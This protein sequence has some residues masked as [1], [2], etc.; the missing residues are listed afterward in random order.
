MTK[1][2]AR[3]SA[4]SPSEYPEEYIALI[5][6]P[7]SPAEPHLAEETPD[8]NGQWWDRAERVFVDINE[9]GQ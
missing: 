8:N 3:R 5:V 7:G 4:F 1:P 6:Q 2:I 9:I